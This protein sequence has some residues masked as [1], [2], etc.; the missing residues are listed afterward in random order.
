MA[1][2][3]RPTY[4]RPIPEGAE[5]CTLKGNPAV[6]HRDKHGRVHV[7]LLTDD[8][9][10]MICEQSRWWMKWQ[11][12]G[13]ETRREKGFRDRTATEQEAARR[14][15][16][17]AR[18]VA[19]FV[20]VEEKHL[21]APLGQHLDSFLEDQSRAGRSEKYREI[22]KSR[23]T[24]M[25]DACG[26]PTLRSVQ[27]STVTPFLASLKGQGL[28]PKTINEYLNA[29]NA[30]LNWCVQQGRLLANP[31]ANVT[32]TDQTVKMRKRRALTVEEV[33]RLLSVAGPRRLLYLVAVTTGIRRGEL[34]TLQWNDVHLDGIR[35]FIA[36][37]AETTKARRADS[38]PLRQ[39]V[40]AELRRARPTDVAPETKVFGRIPRMRDLKPDLAR[41]KIDYMDADGRQAD[42]HSLRMT[43]GTMLAKSGVAPRTAMELMRHTDLRLT[44]NVYTDPRLLNTAGAVEDLP[45][46]TR[47]TE[48]EAARLTGT[49][50]GPA[51]ISTRSK[52]LPKS[53]TSP[54]SHGHSWAQSGRRNGP[55]AGNNADRDVE[56]VEAVGIEPTSGCP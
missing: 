16:E 29:A 12:P 8:G 46:L 32:R 49:D 25:K 11:L 48:F 38:V 40:A 24:K 56:M 4:H 19:G 34:E 17:A 41:A 10:R 47:P 53:T 55:G 23:I 15:R 35:P 6:R 30:F 22:L 45:D 51:D 31:L 54:G 39:D 20:E 5:R 43:F 42:F 1:S 9:K 18:K 2:A 14:E 27:P 13:G 52:V 50:G 44:M 21:L 7:R 37:R 26:W 36:L 28:A 33:Q 3:Y